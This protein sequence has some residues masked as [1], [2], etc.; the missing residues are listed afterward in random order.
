[1]RR[2]K[3]DDRAERDDGD[4]A[5]EVREQR[6]HLV[7]DLALVAVGSTGGSAFGLDAELLR[8]EELRAGQCGDD[9][10]GQRDAMTGNRN[11]GNSHGRRRSVAQVSRSPR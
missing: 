1:M 10:A 7:A 9:P 4:D 3:A 6:R 11:D 5:V 8:G 2:D